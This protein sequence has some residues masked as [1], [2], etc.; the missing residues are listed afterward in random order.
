MNKKVLGRTGLEVPI[1]GLGTMFI[2]RRESAGEG[3]PIL[4]EDLGAQ[5]V[6]AA[7][8][9]GSTWVD[10]APSY[11]RSVSEKII[12]SVLKQRPDLAE[13]CTVVTKAG[14]LPTGEKDHS[15][16]A[17]LSSVQDSLNRLGMSTLEIVYIHDAVGV[18]L[19]QVMGKSGAFAALRKLQDEGVIRF[20]GTATNDP[21][22]NMLY[23]ETGEFDA[24]V[25]PNAWSML[26]Q[27]AA[28]RIL[29]AAEKHN[30]G[31]TCG[32][33]LERGVL[34][35]GPVEGKARG[36][37]GLTPECL[38]HV[39]KIQTLCSDQGISLLEA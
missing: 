2:G 16:S 33:P 26:N 32:T 3:R 4:D 34:A 30:V 17:I 35:T 11:G 12:G 31:I 18:P 13:K 23:V 9:V 20:I 14:N 8:E 37:R 1:V 38:A 25:V 29:P 6:E 5:T 19:E 27:I 24:A 36:R 21:K 7:I 39:S 22:I 10:T 15:F 28:E